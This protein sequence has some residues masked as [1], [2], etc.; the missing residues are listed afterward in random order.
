M[1]GFV[2]Q[3]S[4]LKQELDRAM[5]EAKVKESMLEELSADLE[6]LRTMRQGEEPNADEGQER[7]TDAEGV[8]DAVEQKLAPL[9]ELL[10]QLTRKLE[11]LSLRDGG[12]D[13]NNGPRQVA[14][15][16]PSA[17]GRYSGFGRAN[18]STGSR[19]ADGWEGMRIE[20]ANSL[21][22]DNL[23]AVMLSKTGDANF[24]SARTCWDRLIA[25]YP[26]DPI[27]QPKLVAHAFRG[28]VATVFQQIA[29]ANTNTNAQTLWDLMQ[30]SLYNTAQVQSQRA[31]FT[32]ATMK[33][34]ESVEH[35]KASKDTP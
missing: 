18:D 31:R 22:K 21:N 23:S 7:N 29:A 5:M 14:E 26:V 25:Q 13:D 16:G 17:T 34:D 19:D 6:E 3:N 4:S 20:E 30:G 12:M 1:N 8:E 24:A 9:T 15:A 27:H 2:V 28:A 11:Q 32:S 10:T 35:L 33:K